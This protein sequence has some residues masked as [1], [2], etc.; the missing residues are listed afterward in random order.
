[1]NFIDECECSCHFEEG[2][3]HIMACCDI[4][5]ACEKR[6]KFGYD[7]HVA[8]CKE[9]YIRYLERVLVRELTEEEKK[10]LF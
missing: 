3:Y 8:A 2:V 6:I 1:M 4:C 7:K 10:S 5:P 9:K